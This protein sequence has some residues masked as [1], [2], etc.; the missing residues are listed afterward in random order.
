[1]NN[2]IGNIISIVGLEAIFI[3]IFYLLKDEIGSFS[4]VAILL[5]IIIG[6]IQLKEM[7][8]AN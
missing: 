4:Y 8:T 5:L 6:I 2:N 7:M 3:Y 1:M